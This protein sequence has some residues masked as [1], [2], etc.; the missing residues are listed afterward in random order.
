[1][2][3]LSLAGRCRTK[4]QQ[5]DPSP[6]IREFLRQREFDE[7]LLMPSPINDDKILEARVMPYADDQFMLVVRDVTHLKSIE[8]MRK[9]S[10]PMSH[11]SYVRH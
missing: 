8:N 1:M 6:V 10:W 3:G 11:M 2:S 5:L 7:P 4:Y 9:I